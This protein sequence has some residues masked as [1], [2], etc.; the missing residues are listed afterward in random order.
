VTAHQHAFRKYLEHGVAIKRLNARLLE[1]RPRHARGGARSVGSTLEFDFL[2]IQTLYDRYL[3]ID[4][5][6]KPSRRIETPQF[7]WM[8]VAM[9]LFMDE[10]PG[11]R[12]ERIS[13]LYDLYKNRR[14]CSSTPTLFNS[15]TLHSQ[16][17]PFGDLGNC[18]YW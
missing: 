16:L 17:E 15:G 4:K 18:S 1:L 5:T 11:A 14:F 9:G 12:E 13:G 2:G 3:I 8:R 10:T 7:F 6:R